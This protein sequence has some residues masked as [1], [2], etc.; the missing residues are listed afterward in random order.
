MTRTALTLTALAAS[1]LLVAVPA[2]AERMFV[3]EQMFQDTH[4]GSC[5][6]YT[7]PSEGRQCYGADGTTTYDDVEYGQDT[8]TYTFIGNR[9]CVTYTES[10]EESCAPWARDGDVYTDGEYSW[11]I[12]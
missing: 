9:M 7:G 12:E 3:T 10:P 4:V 11:T 2:Q 8:G 6:V 1:A 5:I